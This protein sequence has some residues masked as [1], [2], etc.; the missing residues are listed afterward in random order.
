M[1]ESRVHMAHS[2]V[3]KLRVL[4]RELSAFITEALAEYDITPSQADFLYFLGTGET[5]PSTISRSIGV[6]PSNLSRMIRQFEERGWLE[7]RTDQANRTRVTLHLTESGRDLLRA[8]DPHAPFV[9]DVIEKPLQ[10]G[11]L[12][13][14]RAAL[15]KIA[16]A[17]DAADPT[18]W[19]AETTNPPD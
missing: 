13:S 3:C 18:G 11:E 12:E 10:S 5:S 8:I 2:L 7:R 9:H 14:L 6:D 16:D 1:T 19:K 17:L 15:G 4:T